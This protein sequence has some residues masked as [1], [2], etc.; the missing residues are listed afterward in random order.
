[1]LS[2]MKTCEHAVPVGTVSMP[3]CRLAHSAFGDSDHC[4]G[5]DKEAGWTSDSGRAESRPG[6]LVM[7]PSRDSERSSKTGKRMPTL[8]SGKN[9]DENN[10]AGH[11]DT[12][13]P[14]KACKLLKLWES[15]EQ[16]SIGAVG[17]ATKRL[18]YNAP[19]P[20]LLSHCHGLTL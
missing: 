8:Q 14:Y 6:P 7:T 16:I 4:N 18:G 15:S 20:G 11:G 1:M 9:R 2:I 19:P 5:A 3:M 10:E 12:R 13:W 17:S